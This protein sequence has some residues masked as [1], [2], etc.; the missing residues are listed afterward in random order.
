[1]VVDGGIREETGSVSFGNYAVSGKVK[2]GLRV[3]GNYYFVKTHQKRTRLERD[4][5]MIFES[6]P[7]A[8]VFEFTL[9]K[10]GAAFS[11]AGQGNTQITLAL[12]PETAYLLVIGGVEIAG[13]RTGTTGKASFGADLTDAPQIITL[14]TY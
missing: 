12:A 6:V 1:M 8:A 5:R 14:R 9:S 3:A 4:G 7:G 11:A 10:Q 2:S 13:V